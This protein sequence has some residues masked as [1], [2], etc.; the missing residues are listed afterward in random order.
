MQK[1][2]KSWSM[3]ATEIKGICGFCRNSQ[4]RAFTALCILIIK[5]AS[6]KIEGPMFNYVRWIALILNRILFVFSQAPI[7]ILKVNSTDNRYKHN[8]ACYNY[9]IHLLFFFNS[10]FLPSFTQYSPY[11]RTIIVRN[12]TIY[13]I[14]GSFISA[15]TVDSSNAVTIYLAISISHFPNSVFIGKSR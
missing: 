12:T 3:E 10:S 11:P 7:L 8:W 5:M 6:L 13:R 15:N 2:K 9:C 1:T 14:I 4:P